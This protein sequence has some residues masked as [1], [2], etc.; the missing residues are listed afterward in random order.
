MNKMTRL[1]LQRHWGSFRSLFCTWE[2]VLVWS[3]LVVPLLLAISLGFGFA[4]TITSFALFMLTM[5]VLSMKKERDYWRQS[6]EL[7][8]TLLE[9]ERKKVKNERKE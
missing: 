1:R 5:T 3:T 7:N 6:Y 4:I 8:R 2:S 9:E